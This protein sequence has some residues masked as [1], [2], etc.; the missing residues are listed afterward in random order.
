MF[1]RVISLYVCYFFFCAFYW[2]KLEMA[3]FKYPIPPK[4]F[5]DPLRVFELF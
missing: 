1:K 2:K 5:F 3:H 4:I